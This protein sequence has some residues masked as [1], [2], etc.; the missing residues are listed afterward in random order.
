[1]ARLIVQ[2]YYGDDARPRLPA[3]PTANRLH[4][5]GRLWETLEAPS[6][7]RLPEWPEGDRR[8]SGA[9]KACDV[10]VEAEA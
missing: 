2:F 3:V 1:M 4:G 8:V 10:T 5:P 9:H 6:A 7:R